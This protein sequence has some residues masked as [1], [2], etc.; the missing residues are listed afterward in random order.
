M[1]GAVLRSIR[2]RR[3]CWACSCHYCGAGWPPAGSPRSC[4]ISV[5]SG[6]QSPT[7]SS[8][9]TSLLRP[10][11]PS[12]YA[13]CGGASRR[14]CYSDLCGRGWSKKD[15]TPRTGRSS[16]PRSRSATSMMG[17]ASFAWTM[18]RPSIGFAFQ[19]WLA[20]CEKTGSRHRC[21]G[22]CR[23]FGL[24]RCGGSSGTHT[25]P[26]SRA[27]HPAVCH[28]VTPAP[29]LSWTTSSRSAS[30]RLRATGATSGPT[31]TPTTGAGRP[32]RFPTSLSASSRGTRGP[33]K[34]G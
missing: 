16:P 1:G 3:P 34:S 29:P 27:S 9:A 22:C 31:S 4:A 23:R 21:L 25:S 12:R 10:S 5:R 11:A 20:A 26:R 6:C 32:R 2:C 8:A 18:H 14:R 7:R 24:S 28:R 33:A 17:A 19:R 13:R 30:R 15:W